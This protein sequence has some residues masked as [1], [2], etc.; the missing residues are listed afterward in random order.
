MRTRAS[1]EEQIAE[2]EACEE[3]HKALSGYDQALQLACKNNSGSNLIDHFPG[4]T[5]AAD[6]LGSLQLGRLR[7]LQNL[8]HIQEILDLAVVSTN[9]S[10]LH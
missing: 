7:C 6:T 9:F 4:L 2:W 5:S 10:F 1:L 3:W 8:G